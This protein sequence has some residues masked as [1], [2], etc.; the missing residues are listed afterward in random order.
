MK[1]FFLVC[2]LLFLN[3]FIS[4]TSQAQNVGIGTDNPISKLDVRGNIALNDNK[5][6][7]R[8]GGDTNHYLQYLGGSYDG[9]KLNGN[10]TVVLSTN[11]SL[12]GDDLVLKNDRVGIN[13]DPSKGLLHVNGFYS[14]DEGGFAYY[15][16]G[17]QGGAGGSTD[18]SI[19]ASNRINATEF[20]ARSDARLKQIIGISDASEDLAKIMAIEITDYTMIDQI[21]G[22]RKI[23]KLIAQQVEMVYPE[24]V[25][26]SADVIPDIY[27]L[28]Q[29]DN[30]FIALHAELEV[31]DHVKIF[32]P[33]NDFLTTVTAVS[34]DGFTVDRD[35]N[36]EVFVYGREVSD[37]RSVDYDAISML[38]VSATQEQ[39]RLIEQLQS[40]NDELKTKVAELSLQAKKIDEVES[41]LSTIMSAL[42]SG[43]I[44]IDWQALQK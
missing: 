7:I 14:S 4:N 9:P 1:N 34:P 32:V 18:I 22:G 25:S 41:Q 17:G 27:T 26:Q 15:A 21:Q 6:M 43:G 42:E 38:N 12:G 20:N 3:F 16:N 40:E 39:Q 30:G 5:L 24:A 44:I 19:Y 2:S 23:K 35:L 13:C 29:A 8:G 36:G 31:G 11:G 33:G 10:A 28:A 37:S